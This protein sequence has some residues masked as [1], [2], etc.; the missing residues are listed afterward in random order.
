MCIGYGAPVMALKEVAA[1]AEATKKHRPLRC[2]PVM[3]HRTRTKGCNE[4]WSAY[5]APNKAPDTTHGRCT[6]HKYRAPTV[7]FFTE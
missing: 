1:R 3:V 7:G 2:A 6:E 4:G 5:N